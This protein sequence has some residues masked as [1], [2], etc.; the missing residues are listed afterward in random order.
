[1]YY[2]TK[3]KK[4]QYLLQKY[5]KNFIG[6]ERRIT[7]IAGVLQVVTTEKKSLIIFVDIIF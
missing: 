4:L 5:F 2:T 7:K 3:V 6:S 1:M